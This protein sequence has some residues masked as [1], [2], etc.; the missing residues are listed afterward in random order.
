MISPPSNPELESKLFE[1]N[2]N[3]K[4]GKLLTGYEPITHHVD[5][6]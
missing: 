1:I 5:F 2:T 4:A 6:L 3:K